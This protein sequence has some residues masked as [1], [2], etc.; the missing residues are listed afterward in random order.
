[1]GMKIGLVGLA[2]FILVGSLV[3]EMT[4]PYNVTDGMA[5]G[6]TVETEKVLLNASVTD[7]GSG[8]GTATYV[9]GYRTT[10]SVRLK[11]IDA[12]EK[13]NVMLTDDLSVL[14]GN[15][16]YIDEPSMK[17]GKATW[18]FPEME[19]GDMVEVS[20]TVDR[21][22]SSEEAMGLPA[23]G[24]S[25]DPLKV[26]IEASQEV[27]AGNNVSV[28]LKTLKGRPVGNAAIHVF[29]PTGKEIIVI[30]D[31]KGKGQFKA[32]EEGVYR[33]LVEGFQLT[34]FV[35]TESIAIN[36][37]QTTASMEG[38]SSQSTPAT[39]FFPVVAGIVVVSL[40]IFVVMGYFSTKERTL[41]GE[42]RT[43]P[44]EEQEFIGEEAPK[45]EI[46]EEKRKDVKET[47][48][49]K[50]GDEEGEE[51]AEEEVSVQE[52]TEP[53]YETAYDFSKLNPVERVKRAREITKKLVELRRTE[54]RTETKKPEGKFKKEFE[55]PKKSGRSS[56]FRKKNGK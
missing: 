28:E 3:A 14:K 49:E 13:T 5:V 21:E 11:N 9:Y 43:A 41:E 12:L 27:D 36:K 24:I 25:S 53:E 6:R 26:V 52:K 32:D 54:R 42:E 38:G 30:T 15:V 47:G 48:E 50:E 19:P 55:A 33:Y 22:L 4:I 1:M 44:R 23:P 39:D 20:Y 45:A 40:V 56:V 46:K 31:E 16:T 7:V 37:S 8:T 29:S 2:L 17:D 18:L 10:I 51:G 34:N 35:E